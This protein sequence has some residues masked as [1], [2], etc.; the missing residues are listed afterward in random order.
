MAS[1]G[2]VTALLGEWSRGNGSALNQL[3]PLV[4]AE[5]RAIAAP[6]SERASRPHVAADRTGSRGLPPARRS[7]SRQLAGPGAFFRRGGAGRP[8]DSDRSRPSSRRE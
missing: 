8:S 3:L 1:S 5:L 6:A 4:Y 2:D 7:A